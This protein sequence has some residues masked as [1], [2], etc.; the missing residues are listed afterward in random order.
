MIVAMTTKLTWYV[1]R[2]GGLVAWA[3]CTASIVWGLL[4]STRLVRRKG[5]PAWLLDLHRFLGALTIVFTL[6]HMAGLYFDK[7]VPFGPRELLVPMASPWRPGAVA[8]GI[9]AFY[10]LLAIG[11]TSLLMRRIKRSWWH[12][13]HLTSFGLF[14]TATVHGFTAGADRT[15]LLVVWLALVGALTV[16]FLVVV[17]LL[18]PR[19]AAR[20]VR[21]AP[22]AVTRSAA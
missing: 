3:T 4:L 15:N 13:V 8:W 7:Y 11:V 6:V 10:V 22:V 1:A 17:R 5:V 9:V 2:A 12:A 16:T 18:A 19:E 21:S 14:V 20:A